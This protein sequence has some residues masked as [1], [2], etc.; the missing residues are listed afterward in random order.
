MIRKLLFLLLLPSILFTTAPLFAA[1]FSTS[2]MGG[3]WYI[4]SIE[5]DPALPAVYWIR[6]YI[7][8]DDAGN[9]SNGAYYG[10]DNSTVALTGGS[11]EVNP[12]GIISGSFTAQGQTGTVVHG[13]LDQSKSIGSAVLIG[14]DNTLDMLTFIKSGGTFNTS[15]LGGKWYG[16]QIIID[17]STGAVFWIYGAYI[18]DDSGRIVS[19]SYTGPDG[20]TLSVTSGL[21][22]VNSSGIISGNIT[23]SNGQ[24]LT[25]VHAKIDQGK[26]RATG[27]SIEPN[28]GMG[29]A[30]LVKAG[31]TFK[32]TDIIAK[33]YAYGV[34]IDPSIPAVYWVYGNLRTVF[35]GNFSGTY[36]APT[37]DV[38][39]GSGLATIDAL[40]VVTANV[41]FSTGDTGVTYIKQDQGKTS[42]VGVSVTNS[43]VMGIWQFFDA[44]QTTLP[45]L[46]LLL[47]DQ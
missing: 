46:P 21:L 32:Q 43:G 29:V 27:V 22:S 18:S 41:S 33:S 31:G 30:Y 24:N 12:Q 2:D 8:V 6:G 15:D 13:K 37:G 44:F 35:S 42:L 9:V 19:G 3:Y 28:G 4:Y 45:G 11:L 39:A 5:I 36:T 17:P 10:P 7:E 20:S 23:L 40:G 38:V 26:T 1:G 25:I 34:I 47:R 14:I 16:Y